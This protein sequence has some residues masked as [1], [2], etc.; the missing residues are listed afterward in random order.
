VSPYTILGVSEEASAAEIKK[1][2]RKRAAELHPDRLPDDPFA[3]TRFQELQSAYD[4]LRDPERRAAL[5]RGEDPAGR[6][7][8]EQARLVMVS[9][10]SAMLEGGIRPGAIVADLRNR[11]CGRLSEISAHERNIEKALHGY[12][13]LL[14]AFEYRGRSEN[15]L[16]A[17]LEDRRA[18]AEEA[19][20]KARQDRRRTADALELLE[21]YADP[22]S[23]FDAGA[24]IST[25]SSTAG[26][27]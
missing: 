20:G 12:D 19:L 10:F 14:G 3:A 2:W 8:F 18:K 26:S 7:A 21:E 1:A 6:L 9:E 27:L 24:F 5:D 4:I 25:S 11:L 23:L 13:E 17:V 22:V 16:E 15:L